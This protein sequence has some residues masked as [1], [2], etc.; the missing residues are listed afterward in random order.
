MGFF[1]FSKGA[2]NGKRRHARAAVVY[3]KVAWSLGGKAMKA[4]K[5]K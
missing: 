1:L 4:F 5:G 3:E 2:D